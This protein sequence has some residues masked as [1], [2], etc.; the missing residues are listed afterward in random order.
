M[1]D[2][3]LIVLM[4][5]VPIAVSGATAGFRLFTQ[6]PGRTPADPE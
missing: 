1:N 6:H 3:L 5:C 2:L 4:I